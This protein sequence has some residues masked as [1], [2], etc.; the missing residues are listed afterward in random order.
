MKLREISIAGFR[1]IRE[2]CSMGL[3]SPTVLAGHN[4]AG[5]SAVI[6]AVLFLLG[7]YDLS[8]PDRT[9]EIGEGHGEGVEVADVRRVDTTWVAGKFDLSRDEEAQ[10][11][12]NSL[13]VRRISQD[14]GKVVL[15]V[16]TEVPE[17]PRLRDFDGLTSALMEDRLETLGLDTT[18]ATKPVYLERLRTAVGE[19]AK[20]QAWVAA[21]SDINKGL[22]DARRFDSTSAVDAEVAIRDVLVTKYRQHLESD[23][24]QGRVRDVEE[25]LESLL[26]K[27]S[28]DIKTFVMTKVRDIGAVEIS[29]SVSFTSA[30]GLKSTDITVRNQANE[31]IDLRLSGAGRARRIA[32]AVWEY[33]A[34]LL[35]ESGNDIVLL[36]DEPDTH[37]DYGHQREL[38]GLIHEQTQNAAVTVLIA[39]H[40]MN[41]IDGTDIK[42]VVHVKHEDHR[43]VIERLADDSSVGSH[44]GSIAASVGLRNTVL[45]HERLFVGVEGESEARVIPVLFKLATGRHLESCG[46]AI[47]PCDNNEGARHFA[48]FLNKHGRNVAFVVDEDSRTNTKHVFSPSK[49][50]AAGLDPNVHCFYIGDPTEIEDVFTDEQWATAANTCWPRPGG[51]TDP[52]LASHFREHRGGKF[53][54]DICEMVR[55][56]ADDCAPTGKPDML[57]DL[58]LTLKSANDVPESL[59]DVFTQLIA[60]AS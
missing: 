7:K 59:R 43:T 36:Y 58:V 21:N 28:T 9:Y 44:L 51:M 27:D 33:N 4:D 17:D 10:F 50:T 16:L 32:L 37:L 18:K 23:S 53:S 49:L 15:E 6:D 40:S 52:W 39:S 1:S 22:P 34:S 19:E 2:L 29:P 30:N 8:T 38:M 14:G 12:T 3:G 41:L 47:W 24:F 31:R 46:I 11:G 55:T 54:K 42:D 26:V 5:K 25:E 56:N 35:A 20:V 57:A 45:L 48:K 13:N 60:R